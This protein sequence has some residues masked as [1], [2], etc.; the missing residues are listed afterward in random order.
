M[1]GRTDHHDVPAVRRPGR[2]RVIDRQRILEAARTLDPRSLTMKAV[3][4]ALG[5]DPKAVNYHVR[6]RESLLEML[7]SD[8]FHRSFEE[9]RFSADTDW[10][11]A[12]RAFATAI[13]EG[14]VATGALSVYFRFENE[15]ERGVLGPAEGTLAS[16]VAAGF[17]ERTA[18]HTLAFIA[19]FA[20]S[21]ARNAI[22]VAALDGDR[23]LP[24][25]RRALGVADVDAYPIMRRLVELPVDPLG[26]NQFEFD[27]RVLVL[28]LEQILST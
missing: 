7:A 6:D 24:D 14:V 22:G 9:A 21:S 19:E 16:L 25:L 18:G 17:D 28:G 23:P 8:A 4:D 26:H 20:V 12:V 27:L 10:R 15:R 2:P 3:A 1:S 13:R 5:V 11:V